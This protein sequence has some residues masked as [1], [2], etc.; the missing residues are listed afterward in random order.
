MNWSKRL[1]WDI[2]IST[3]DSEKH[4]RFII[5][6]ILQRGDLGD[7]S[8]LKRTYGIKRIK[9]EAIKIRALD[10]K[11]LALLSVILD[12]PKEQFRCYSQIQ[13]MRKHTRY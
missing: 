6:R 2:D 10:G 13:S 11:T 7:W 3:L 8:E 5:E 4:S 1:F 9:D 12:V